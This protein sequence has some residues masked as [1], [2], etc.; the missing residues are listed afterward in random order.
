[1]QSILGMFCFKIICRNPSYGGN[2][3]IICKPY[4]LCLVSLWTFMASY[5]LVGWGIGGMDAINYVNDFNNC[6][7]TSLLSDHATS[8]LG[9]LWIQQAIR[10]ITSNYH[11]FFIIAYAFIAS[12][13]IV[14]IHRF[15]SKLF[16]I[17]PL[18]LVFYL[19][20]RG[21]NTLR[22]NVTISFILLG[23]V[24]VANSK[25]KWAYS[26]FL[27]ACLMHKAGILYAF[28]IPY[29]H[30]VLKKGI[31][32]KYLFYIGFILFFMASWLRDLFIAFA[33]L[34]DLGGAYGSYARIA[35]ENNDFLSGITENSMQYLLSVIIIVFAHKIKIITS[36][37][38]E[39][40]YNIINILI[41]ICFFDIMLIPFNVMLGIWRGYEFFYIPRVCMWSVLLFVFLRNKSKRF[42][43]L[44]NFLIFALFVSWFI[45]RLNRTYSDSALMPYIFDFSCF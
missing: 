24:N 28:S 40:V 4:S 17:I 30:L 34:N 1:M 2:F 45:F 13:Y 44:I 15:S 39:K 21:Y 35:K 38:G 9:F 42:K 37:Y 12:S 16:N 26:C 20:L 19:Y 33:A 8:D 3:S 5:R 18:L 10:H 29:L 11:L 36:H 43:A 7:N 32:I 14:F 25:Y 6:I 41:Y 23:L 27:G 22:S 31:K